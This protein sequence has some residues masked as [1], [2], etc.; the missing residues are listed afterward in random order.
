MLNFFFLINNF[1]YIVFKKLTED[2]KSNI[3][4]IQGQSLKLL[5]FTNELQFLKTVCV[6]WRY[7]ICS[8]KGKEGIT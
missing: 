2:F 7:G 3:Q 5:K 6:T 8:Y 4:R 1:S